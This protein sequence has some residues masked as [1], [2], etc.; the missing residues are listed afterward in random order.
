METSINSSTSTED[1]VC[2]AITLHGLAVLKHCVIETASNERYQNRVSLEKLD[3][4]A[5]KTKIDPSNWFIPEEYK[6]MD[7]EEYLIEQCPREN[8]QRLALELDLFK[9]NDMIMVLKAMKF[10]V[11]TM[12]SNN[13]VWGVGRGSSV[14]SYALYLI[15]IHKIDPIKY[16]LPITE[17]FK[18]E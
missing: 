1:D 11:D 10:L 18:G 9:K 3:Y 6:N 4:P 13:V 14:A 7:I 5:I 15:G 8:L 12:R 2:R 16:N 17:F